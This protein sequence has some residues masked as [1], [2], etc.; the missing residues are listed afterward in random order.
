MEVSRHDC[1]RDCDVIHLNDIARFTAHT[2][3]TK[4]SNTA[5]LDP[6]EHVIR[7]VMIQNTKQNRTELEG[8]VCAVL[9]LHGPYQPVHTRIHSVPKGPV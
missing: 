8:F 4:Q 2:N 1:D 6:P 7:H 9:L 5:H 3:D